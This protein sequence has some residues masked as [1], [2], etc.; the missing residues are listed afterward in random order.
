MPKRE[1]LLEQGIGEVS[2][3]CCHFAQMPGCHTLIEDNMADIGTWMAKM[4][5]TDETRLALLALV[6]SVMNTEFVE[7]GYLWK[8]KADGK[9]GYT[10]ISDQMARD[11]VAAA[12]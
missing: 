3:V 2:A 6:A 7:T 4:L 5:A 12:M 1:E 9:F 10:Y 11:V 8:V